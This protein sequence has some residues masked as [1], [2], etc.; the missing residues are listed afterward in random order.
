MLPNQATASVIEP[1]FCPLV[2]GTQDI[3]LILNPQGL[4][5]SGNVGLD[6]T[7]GNLFPEILGQHFSC[8]FPIEDLQLH[9]PQQILEIASTQGTFATEGWHRHPDGSRFWG[10]MMIHA[11]WGIGGELS[12]FSLTIRDLGHPVL[13]PSMAWPEFG[14]GHLEIFNLVSD[15]MIVRDLNDRIIFWNQAAER[16]YGW[17]APEVQGQ[18]IHHFL[19]TNFPKAPEEVLAEFEQQ[20][21]WQGELEHCTKTGETVMVASRWQLQRDHRGQPSVKLEINLDITSQKAALH[22]RQQAQAQLQAQA[23]FLQTIYEGVATLI[24]VVDV[25][26][27]QD[28]RLAS[29]NAASESSTGISRTL[30]Q[31]KTPEEVF[32]L[33]KGEEVRARYQVCVETEHSITYEELI[34]MQGNDQWWL[35]TCSP[36]RDHTGRIYR[37]VGS[38]VNITERKQAEAALR[39]RNSL[40]RSILDSTPDV[41]LVKDL[42]GKHVVLNQATA[43]YFE[44]PMAA[45]VGK[46]DRE[47]F[48]PEIAIPL[49]ELD[50]RVMTTGLTDH[51]E[52]NVSKAGQIQTYSGVRSPWRDEQGAVRGMICIGRDIT[53]RKQAEIALQQSKQ[54]LEEAQRLAHIGSWDFAIASGTITWSDEVYCIHGLI[55]G[56]SPPSYGDLLQM[57]H[58]DDRDIFHDCV[59]RA[60]SHGEPYQLEFRILRPDG[61]IRYADG[62]G[63]AVFDSEGKI[64][65][66]LGTIMDITDRK[67]IE[68]ERQLA[69]NALRESEAALRQKADDL[70][71]IVTE[72]QRTQSQLVQSEKMSSLGQLV[73]GVAHEINNPVNFIFG[74]LT[75]AHEYI[76]DLLNLLELY[77]KHYPQPH[78]EIVSEAEA[79]DL[80][81]LI[82]DLPK[83]LGSMKVGA[84]RIQTIVRSLRNFSRMDEAEMKAV[85]IHEGLD[86]TL[87]ILQNRL[88]DKP[89][90]PA[91]EVIKDYGN[92]PLV[93][94]YA[95]QLNQVFMN[96][97]SNAIDALEERD[98]TR[99]F[100]Q[101]KQH[102]SQIQIRTELT[103]SG[104][105]RIRLIDNG[106]GMTEAV[107]AQ[108]TNPFFTTKPIGKGT[109]LGMS[110]SYQIITDKHG[111]TLQ[112]HSQPGE[113]A[114]FIL[115]IPL[116]Q[117]AFLKS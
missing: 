27:D 95:G 76:Q 69:E 63:E 44:M 42:Q 13:L 47:L 15:A 46:D 56:T 23:D 66:L 29:W 35:T 94:C 9:Q 67:Q 96:I 38:T 113:G 3:M 1:N 54:Q 62:K 71:K 41:I 74:N 116:K 25:T 21:Y 79:I 82:E 61:E 52:V 108:I 90:H 53:D 28:F 84:D 77:Q 114:E 43:D 32:G 58:P 30:I 117:S 83:L 48:P 19:Q 55:P 115:E 97:L 11:L 60:I 99:T 110:I 81:F 18:Y 92:L 105:V 88:K 89:E 34:P 91:I 102:P 75:H 12:G 64:V 93:E 80:E 73:A 6:Q 31:G 101:M 98:K 65:R 106:P 45:I 4:I 85:D 86:S 37:I 24:F 103:S 36:L 7:K 16:L 111:G 2:E 8:F 104:K 70:E 40:L 26:E 50:Q 33:E 10:Q 22:D 109:G 78:A 72:L 107:K 100:E 49:M 59:S 5:L 51:S 87:M 17:T 68:I 20:G 57:Y 14:F 39:E 112:C